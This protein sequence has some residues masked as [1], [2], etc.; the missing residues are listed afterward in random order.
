[1]KVLITGSSGFI[2]RWVAYTLKKSGF[3]IL[4]LDKKLPAKPNDYIETYLCNILEAEKLKAYIMKV[5]PQIIIHL[6]AR[7]DLDET[8][9]LQGYADNIDGVRNLIDAIKST[10]SVKR[11]IYTSSQ[12]VCKV[13]YKPSSGTDYCPNT[14]YGQ[15]KVQTEKIVRAS[16]GGNVEWC[17]VRPTTVWGPHMKEHYQKLLFLIQKGWYFHCGK[18]KLLKSY[19]YVGNI[20]YQYLQL[21]KAPK[22]QIHQKT[23]YLAD[24][25]PLSLRDYANGL[26]KELDAPKIRSY[27][28]F[29]VKFLA[30]I[31]DLINLAGLK[32]FPFNSFRLNNIMTKYIFNLDE[33]AKICGK[34]PYSQTEGIKAT[35]KWFLEQ[36]IQNND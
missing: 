34:L 25:N 9:N 12:L 36:K 23:L 35:A 32:S 6:A 24:Y 30:G 11:A 4:G 17:L 20:A 18:D 1:M 8:T 22:E 31:G 5:S 10:P 15:S 26:A 14:L 7:T 13:G 2:G 3:N 21:I 27:P 29:A 33:T 16:D 19:S 28:L